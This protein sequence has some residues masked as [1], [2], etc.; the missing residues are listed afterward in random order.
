M[1]AGGDG[2]PHPDGI[3]AVGEQIE[4]ACE[5]CHLKY[6]YPN[7]VIPPLRSDLR[8]GTKP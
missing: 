1:D 4:H 6:W 7:Q 5:S 2:R 8:P 3:M